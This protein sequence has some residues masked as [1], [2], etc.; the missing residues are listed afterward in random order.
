MMSVSIVANLVYKRELERLTP[1]QASEMETFLKRKQLPLCAQFK[2]GDI[3]KKEARQAIVYDHIPETYKEYF[4]AKGLLTPT[5]AEERNSAIYTEFTSRG[6]SRD[7]V[8][9]SD[10]DEGAAD[11]G[12][13]GGAGASAE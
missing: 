4:L 8:D 3:S 5:E 10:E 7:D 12:E 6:I 1:E 13:S 2:S 11:S 9:E